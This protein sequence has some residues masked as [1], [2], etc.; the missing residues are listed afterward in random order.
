MVGIEGKLACVRVISRCNVVFTNA[1]VIV[2]E[3]KMVRAN[4]PS[5][6]NVLLGMC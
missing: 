5:W 2:L 4:F 3:A 6:H 1:F